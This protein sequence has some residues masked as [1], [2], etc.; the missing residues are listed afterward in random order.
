[1]IIPALKPKQQTIPSLFQGKVDLIS[2]K[3]IKDGR[4]K[5]FEG[6]YITTLS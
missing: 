1:M 2:Q 3:E 6:Q 5:H 4:V